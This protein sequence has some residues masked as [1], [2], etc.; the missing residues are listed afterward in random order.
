MPLC[1]ESVRP[2]F[3]NT[4]HLI[5]GAAPNWI[6]FLQL[7]YLRL[8]PLVFYFAYLII[9]WEKTTSLVPL[10]SIPRLFPLSNITVNVT[11]QNHFRWA[12]SQSELTSAIQ[13]DPSKITYFINIFFCSCILFLNLWGHF[14]SDDV[15]EHEVYHD[16]FLCL[17]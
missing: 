5:N 13:K 9:F 6:F 7:Q 8:S 2:I 14:S 12:T 10:Q 17:F 16:P 1:G 11:T 15:S 3:L 4:V